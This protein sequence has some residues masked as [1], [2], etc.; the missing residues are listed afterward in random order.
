[1]NKSEKQQKKKKFFGNNIL[2]FYEKNVEILLNRILF[3]SQFMGIFDY[4][5]LF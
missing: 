4:K 1:M 3:F 5:K 2:I